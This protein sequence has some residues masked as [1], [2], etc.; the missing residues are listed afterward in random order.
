VKQDRIRH[1]LNLLDIRPVVKQRKWLNFP[2]PYAP[3][4]HSRGKD[5]KPSAGVEI[6][7]GKRSHFHC[8]TC[9]T[10]HD[11]HELPAHIG[12]LRGEDLSGMTRDMVLDE[13]RSV[14]TWDADYDEEDEPLEPLSDAAYADLYPPAYQ[15][16]M[17]AEYLEGRD[18][19]EATARLLE[20]GWDDYEMRVTFPVRDHDGLLYGFTGRTVLEEADYPKKTYPRIRD[21][22]GLPKRS[23]I[24][25]EH[26]FERDKPI[27]VVEG[28]FG[29]AH[30]MNI[31]ADRLANIGAL[32]G[33][34]M[35][36]DKATRLI[37]W[38]ENTYLALDPDAGGDTGMWGTWDS[39]EGA[40]RGGGAVDKLY[41]QVPLYIPDW[42]EDVTDPDQLTLEDVEEMLEDT[43][44]Y[45]GEKP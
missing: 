22:Y 30:L 24:L 12:R 4:R 8:F 39:E 13:A 26:L 31:G 3:W 37:E 21:Y 33:S 11:F 29:F 2:C 23:L 38:G 25:G 43:P 18:I 45:Q 41:Q 28:L 19:D 17:A 32:M 20:I 1:Y 9:N 6:R 36:D 40:F 35:T 14:P 44:L 5:T 27:L 16:T 42:P 10:T 15:N 7:E 34:E